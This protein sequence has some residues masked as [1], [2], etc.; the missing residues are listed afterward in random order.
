MAEWRTIWRKAISANAL[1]ALNDPEGEAEFRRLLE[2][3]NNDPMVY[4][5]RGEA[6]E[7]LKAF[8]LAESDYTFA[9]EHLI[10]P[11]WRKVAQDALASVRYQK[12]AS[13]ASPPPTQSDRRKRVHLLHE[14]PQLPHEVRADAISAAARLDSEPRLAAIEFRSCL[15]QL[16]WVVVDQR[17]ENPDRSWGLDM[18]VKLL[19]G[20]IPNDTYPNATTVQ[21]LGN[22]ATHPHGKEPVDFMPVFPAFR[23]VAKWFC[24]SKWSGR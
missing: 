7:Y 6:Y 12:E 2:K 24:A 20:T 18:L 8:D 21:Q 17:W 14:L 3:Y 22:E 11:Q 19:K 16:L 13:R 4:Y 10:E 1:L 9:A 5:E 23:E 15:E